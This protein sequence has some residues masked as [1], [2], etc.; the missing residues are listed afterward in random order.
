MPD[1]GLPTAVEQFL[2]DHIRSIEHLEVLLTV[3]SNPQV[4][5]SPSEVLNRVQSSESSVQIRLEEF[6]AAGLIVQDKEGYRFSPRTNELREAVEQL[7]RAYKERRV[8]VVEAI[9][10]ERRHAARDLSEA[11]R[12][13]RK[14]KHG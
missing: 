1:P 13:R 7:T 10:S 4:S 2:S 8:R 12:F 11:F 3:T 6:V 14:D 5:W 9:Y